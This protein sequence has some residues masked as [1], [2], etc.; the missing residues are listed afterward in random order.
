MTEPPRMVPE[1]E[2]M[3]RAAARAMTLYERAAAGS[4]MRP[5]G[6]GRAER[7][8]E[9]WRE[10]SAKGD[11]AEFRRRLGEDGFDPDA[12]DV[13]LGDAIAAAGAPLPEWTCFVRSAL[14]AASAWSKE[15]IFAAPPKNGSYPF[16]ELVRPFAEEGWRRLLSARPEIGDEARRAVFAPARDTLLFLLANQAAFAFNLEFI[17]NKAK[18]ES[19]L[20]AAL[21]AAR[22]ERSDRLYRAFV[23]EFFDGRWPT[24]I[25]EYAVLARQL[26][27]LCIGWAD[28]IAEMLGRLDED[29]AALAERFNR[30]KQFGDPSGLEYGLSDRHNE[31]RSTMILAWEGGPR[32]VYKPKPLDTDLLVADLIDWIN[33]GA[34]LLPLA[35][36]GTLNRGSHGWQEYVAHEPCADQ[37]AVGRFYVRAGYLLALAYALEGYDCH[38]EN[39]I[40]RGEQPYLIDTETIFNPYKEMDMAAEDGN[41]AALASET[42]YYS[43]ARTGLLPNWSIKPGG[44]KRD[45]SGFGGGGV[46]GNDDQSL[47]VWVNTGTDDIRLEPRKVPLPVQANQPFT[48][49]SAGSADDHVADIVA[50]F[51]AMYRFLQCNRETLAELIASRS[52]IQVRFV[53]KATNVYAQQMWK[54]ANPRFLREGVDWSIEADHMARMY[55]AAGRNGTAPW[56]MLRAE[57]EA[58][59]RL[60]IPFFRVQADGLDVVDGAGAVRAPGYFSTGCLARLGR[61]LD[62]LDDEDLALQE[63]YIEYAF[64]ARA[65]RS[66]H[67]DP[68]AVAALTEFEKQP[69]GH[70]APIGDE[71]CIAVAGEI[72]AELSREA[73]RAAD[74]SAAWIALEYLKEADAFQFKPIS[75][76]LYS[77]AIGLAVFLA[78]LAKTGGKAE[79]AD[80]SAAAAAPILRAIDEELD[81]LLR[82]GTVGGGNGLGSIIYGLASIADFL[83]G[84]PIAARAESAALRCAGHV[85]EPLLRRDGKFDL[86]FGSAGLLLGLAKLHALH[87]D[88]AL[89][90]PI[91]RTADYMLSRCAADGPAKG[92]IATYGGKPI[93]GMSHGAAGIALALMRAQAATGDARYGEAAMAHVAFEEDLWDEE[94]GNYPD[95]RSTPDQKAFLTSWCHGTPGIGLSRV[96]MHRIAGDPALLA[97][98]ARSMRTTGAFTLDHVDHICC[99]N[100]GRIDVQLE[101]ARATG[102]TA[103]ADS[104]R[105]DASYV[106]DRYRRTGS[107]R[108]LLNAPNKVFAP[109]MF[110]GAAG[111]AYGLLRLADPTLPC[112][113]A[114]E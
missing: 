85:D 65:A 31:G 110:T 54:L 67:D 59:I 24:F 32:I 47:S 22:G 41:A 90:D 57:H 35:S 2:D 91:V 19:Q 98:A 3:A 71:E 75:F 70:L 114:Y 88:A 74:G 36:A 45:T 105:R 96:A 52:D 72:A 108:L 25:A 64:H 104:L 112:V 53:R 97:Q 101:Y 8:A 82:Y 69:T 68:D 46:E 55:V 15:E 109:G 4:R 26:A 6:P 1:N 13:L 87:G 113:L 7:R 93:T 103:L 81:S 38:H 89:A 33:A 94:A 80:L 34:G 77:G 100:I 63:R 39:L 30:G 21:R 62:R 107:F 50:G 16:H 9:R 28:S 17:I 111:I 10:T 76:N 18:R 42:V 58:M 84:H 106:V 66:Y 78:A 5:A 48:P 11:E 27:A 14:G 102:D 73:V 23:R 95:Y 37:A 92:L 51:R 83:P 60:D 20:A 99:G 61:K 44:A 49:Q 40:A 12:L 79:H 43:V 29:R 86:I 56:G